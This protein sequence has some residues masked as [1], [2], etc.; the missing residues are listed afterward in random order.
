[1]KTFLTII[2]SLLI[3]TGYLS[4]QNLQAFMSYADFNTPD[5]KPYI[6]TYLVINGQSLTWMLQPD[7]TFQ[8]GVDV[9]IIFRDNDSAIINFD[10][11]TLNS[12]KIKDTSG[13]VNN[14]MNVERYHLPNGQ[15]Q[16]E[17]TINDIN[18]DEKAMVNYDE[19]AIDYPP[20]KITFSEIELVHSFEKSNNGGLLE[21]N[22]YEIVP[23]ALD[24]YPEV[25]HNLTFYAE[26]YNVDSVAA[27]GQFLLYYYIRPAELDKKL[28]Q[29][30]YAKRME[31]KPV[32]I[33]LNSVD[34]TSLPSGNYML[35][36]EARDRKNN[37]VASTQ[38]FF[39]RDNPSVQYN[40]TSMLKINP[41]NSF[42]GHIN[43]KD[44]LSQYIDY[45]Y[46][47]S[48]EAERNY[49]KSLFNESDLATMQKFFLNFWIQRDNANPEGAWY[50]YKVRVDQVNTD[51]NAGRIKGYK[52]DRGY[53]YLKY[54]RPNV[55]AKSYNEPAAYPYEIWHYYSMGHQRD[56][57]FV[58][59]TRDLTTNDFQLIHSTAVGEVTNPRWQRYVYGRTWDP[60]DI[61]T[62][63][64][65]STYGSFATE[66]YLQPR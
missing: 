54:G 64:I 42:A 43:S 5:N 8:A 51:F 22:G 63:I 41:E 16:L 58:F 21:K 10:K 34:I 56:I 49:A 52:T 20:G 15:Y 47:I 65:P 6:E 46:P 13:A 53:V 9:K 38:K 50:E 7:G 36:L 25:A 28:P 31:A 45:L 59:V 24:Y 17:L 39:Y 11:Y 3:S 27:D 37:L 26:L 60:L 61:D 2:I 62:E 30:F 12:P 29:Y 66:Y 57:R 32:K 40:Y 19:F 48:T 4:A 14:L 1:M 33:M 18:S 44:T 55:I 23:Y 35:V